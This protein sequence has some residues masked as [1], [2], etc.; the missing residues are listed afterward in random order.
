MN[1]YESIFIIDP[2]LPEDQAQASVEKI[3][4]IISQTAG[5]EPLK[6]D[7]W[8]IRRLAYRVKKKLRGHFVL[9]HFSGPPTL[10][11]ELH[12]NFRVMDAVIKF[13]SVRLDE[14]QESSLKAPPEELPEEESGAGSGV[15]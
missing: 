4:G 9:A 10:L 6:V 13:Q 5:A 15:R 3:K 12:R 2:D 14:Q 8:G 11:S 7:D 1:R